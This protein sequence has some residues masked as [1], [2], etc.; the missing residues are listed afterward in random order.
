[1]CRLCCQSHGKEHH[2]LPPQHPSQPQLSHPDRPRTARVATIIVRTE[3]FSTDLLLQH[4]GIHL[5]N[6]RSESIFEL[7]RRAVAHCDLELLAHDWRSLLILHVHR[8]RSGLVVVAISPAFALGVR[9]RSITS[10]AD[11]VC[12]LSI[13]EFTT[14][15]QY[16]TTRGYSHTPCIC[17]VPCRRGRAGC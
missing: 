12:M 6:A 5:G 17:R 1:M 2:P 15:R 10:S 14:N 8:E 7:L 3:A 11:L 4:V 13:E 9:L 16:K